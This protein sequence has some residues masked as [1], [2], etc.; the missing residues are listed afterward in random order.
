MAD[1]DM[2][3]LLREITKGLRNLFVEARPDWRERDWELAANI[4]L[5]KAK[6]IIYQRG[7]DEGVRKT[8]DAADSTFSAQ[9]KEAKKQERER[10]IKYCEEK[11]AEV[12]GYESYDEAVADGA[13]MIPE[14]WQALK[15][16][17]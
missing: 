13:C 17:K 16:E 14:Y 8:M 12:M 15:G 4:I 10:I 6:P 9:L 11:M 3:L 5:A 1:K 2:G 7:F